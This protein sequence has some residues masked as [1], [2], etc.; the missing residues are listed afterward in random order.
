MVRKNPFT[1]AITNIV[2]D[3]R[4][5]QEAAPKKPS[6]PFGQEE[7]TNAQFLERWKSMSQQEKQ[8]LFKQPGMRDK[9]LE[10]ARKQNA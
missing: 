2:T 8:E 6:V 1:E 4:A 3:F 5:L 10:L 7:V 9:V